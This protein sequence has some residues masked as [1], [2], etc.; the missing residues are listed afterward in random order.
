MRTTVVSPEQLLSFAKLIHNPVPRCQVC[1]IFQYLS[2][3]E[4][5]DNFVI[6]DWSMITTCA[7]IKVP[8][9]EKAHLFGSITNFCHSIS[10]TSAPLVCLDPVLALR[11][12][13]PPPNAPTALADLIGGIDRLVEYKYNHVMYKRKSP[14]SCTHDG[15][16]VLASGRR[17]GRRQHAQEQ[18]QPVQ[19]QALLVCSLS[20]PCVKSC[21]APWKFLISIV[22]KSVNFFLKIKQCYI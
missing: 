15:S 13:S 14:Y 21:H 12:S 7:T 4:K 11:L 3:L 5:A 1:T 10:T 6:H 2:L 16:L 17:C 8:A 19:T 20:A 18:P 22:A 9:I